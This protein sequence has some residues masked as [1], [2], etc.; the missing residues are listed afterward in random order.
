MNAVSTARLHIG[1]L[2][3]FDVNPAMFATNCSKFKLKVARS[4][5]QISNLFNI[6]TL[7]HNSAELSIRE[8]AVA[9]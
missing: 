6:G 4:S 3:P 8:H 2:F 1:T 5:E 7:C 9:L